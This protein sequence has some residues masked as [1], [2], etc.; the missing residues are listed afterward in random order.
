MI[1]R[2]IPNSPVANLVSGKI[3][4]SEF[5]EIKVKHGYKEKKAFQV[6]QSI[7]YDRGNRMPNLRPRKI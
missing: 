3:T 7:L 1:H 6:A 5:M 2:D 4:I